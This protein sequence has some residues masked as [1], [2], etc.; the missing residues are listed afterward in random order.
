MVLDDA[1]GNAIGDALLQPAQ[2]GVTPVLLWLG[3]LDWSSPTSGT[4]HTH[5]DRG[6][7]CPVFRV[8]EK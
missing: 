8:L 7:S 3:R 4:S 5:R 1:I 6:V 2:V